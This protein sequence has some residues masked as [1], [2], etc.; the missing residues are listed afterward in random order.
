MTQ[1]VHKAPGGLLRAI[2]ETKDGR[3]VRVSLSGDF[4]CYPGD[5]LAG[6]EDALA[7]ASPARLE[8]ALASFFA[9]G[10]VTIPGVGIPDWLAV[11]GAG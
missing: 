8:S 3:I 2:L 1:R 4:F 9:D 7:G 10:R 6:L 5:A 11:L